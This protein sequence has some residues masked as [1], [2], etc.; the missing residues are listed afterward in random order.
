MPAGVASVGFMKAFADLGA[1]RAGIKLLGTG[2]TD[3]VDLPAIGDSALGVITG[4]HYSLSLDSARNRDFVAAYRRQHGPDAIPNFLSVAAYDGMHAIYEVVR[5]LGG[6]ID[7]DRVMEVLKGMQIDSPRGSITIDAAERDI[8]QDV[9]IRRVERR[10]A[11]LVNVAFD[12]FE[13]VRDPWK[14]QNRG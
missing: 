14:D 8:V 3:E 7:G 13:Q 11:M 2:E 12:K 5:R 6:P 9:Y 4:Y 10:D 1:H